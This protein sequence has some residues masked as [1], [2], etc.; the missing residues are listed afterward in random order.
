MTLEGG[1]VVLEDALQT[2]VGAVLGGKLGPQLLDDA[3]AEE[4]L[5]GAVK[6]DEN[7]L[8]IS[9]DCQRSLGLFLVS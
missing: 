7:K 6:K 3:T 4:R 5:Q 9:V 1:V 2:N 8:L